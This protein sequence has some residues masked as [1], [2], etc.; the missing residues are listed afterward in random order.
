MR[1]L[2]ALLLAIFIFDLASPLQVRAM[3]TATEIAK[4]AAISKEVDRESLLV[5]DPFLTNWVNT[6]GG[7]LAKF[8]ARED[9]NFTFSIINSDEINAF[10]LPGGFVHVDMGLLNAVSSDDELAGVL[11]HEMGHVER[12]HFLSLEE[13]STVLGILVGVLSILSPIASLFGGDAGELAMTKFSRVDELQADQYG[14]QL[15]SRAG[16]DPQSMVDFMDQLRKMS[17]SPES[18]ADKAF[19]DHPVPSD[20]IA[21]LEGYPQLDNPTAAQI[22]ADAIHDESEGR[23]SYADARYAQAL[24]VESSDT[25]AS[26][27]V[28]GLQTALKDTGMH[29]GPGSPLQFAF[30]LDP[31]GRASTASMIEQ[32]LNITRDD[33]ALAREQARWGNRDAESLATQLHSLSGGVPNLGQPKTANNNLAQAT[34]ALDKM[35]VDINGALSLTADVMTTAPGLFQDNQM[36]LRE[37]G[38]QLVDSEATI[39]TQSV[40]AYYPGISAQ[41]I[42]SSD[43]LAR[44]V[45]RA[46]GA[47]SS[48]A[49][50]VNALKDY[51]VVLDTIDT[52]SGDIKPADMPKVRAA[53]DK[54]QAAWDSVEAM[55]LQSD[56]EIY[57][58]Q[59]RWLAARITMLDLTSSQARYDWFRKALAYRFPGVETPEYATLTRSGVSPGEI[60]CAA[61]LS[62]ET[63]TP[64]ATLMS[65]ALAS[66]ETC[67][68]MALARGV[69]T[70]SMEIAQGLVYQDYIDKPHKLK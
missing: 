44:A 20:R 18:K 48:A 38:Q 64:I 70:E 67:E 9:I 46:R 50:S 37:M 30:E 22:T 54:A 49:D 1:T 24:H 28:A 3:S 42:S 5:D 53:L 39:G 61:W 69:L 25:L 57:T 6:V 58:A 16:Y 33:A 51:F 10:A 15:M 63:K 7:N 21:H 36:L 56:D 12:R 8:R 11:A 35:I 14:L 65:Q 45:D 19:L 4:G 60:S 17:E 2:A 34:A 13:K 59:S 27:H 40:Q 32:A 66:G 41:M 68:D 23:F 26:S 47:V 43:E 55:A 31:A 29:A 62:Y 52:S